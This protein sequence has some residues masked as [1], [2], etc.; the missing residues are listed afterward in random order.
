MRTW[1]V[2]SWEGLTSHFSA[3]TESEARQSAENFCRGSG[4]VKEWTEV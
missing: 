1:R 4:G 3:Y 2:V